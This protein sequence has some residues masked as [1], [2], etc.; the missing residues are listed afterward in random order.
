MMS[1]LDYVDESYNSR[2]FCVGGV[3]GRD[4]MWPR[5]QASWVRRIN[6]ENRTSARNGFPPIS[7]YHATDCANLKKEFS[8]KN[9]WDI[10]RQIKLTKRLCKIIG[11]H[12][13]VGLVFGGS[14]D[15]VQ[16]YLPPEKERAKRCLYRLSFIMHML[17]VGKIMER[18][19]PNDRVSVFYDRSKEFGPIAEAAFKHFMED[20]GVTH[21]AKYFVTCASMSWEDCVPLQP[22]DFMTYE[23]MKRVDGRLRGKDEIKKSLAAL[24]GNQIPIQIGHFSD[25]NFQDALRLEK[26]SR[27]VA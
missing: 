6:H 24:L 8:E 9:G 18:F 4:D 14:L 3:L 26:K 20:K 27:E 25:Q 16:K 12:P 22:A 15:D 2:T 13:P 1:W 23:G 5:L 21:L 10:D 19:F 17:D 11:E 7:R